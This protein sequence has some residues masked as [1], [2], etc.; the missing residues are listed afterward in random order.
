M[1]L[2]RKPEARVGFSPEFWRELVGKIVAEDETLNDLAAET[3][4]PREVLRKWALTAE[5]AGTTASSVGE[6]LVPASRVRELEREIE[7][8]RRLLGR[9][10]VRVDVLREA[11]NPVSESRVEVQGP[12]SP[13]LHVRSRKTGARRREPESSR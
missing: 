12:A 11:G 13:V 2:S 3:G 8:L 5:R 1:D 4:I 7:E 10:A 9:Q 6:P